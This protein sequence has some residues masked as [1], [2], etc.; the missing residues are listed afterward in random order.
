MKAICTFSL[1]R[2]KVP[3][4]E[5]LGLAA[6]EHNSGVIILV[7]F[8]G[9]RSF[10]TY[11][12]SFINTMQVFLTGK[13]VTLGDLGNMFRWLCFL[14]THNRLPHCSSPST[15]R[16]EESKDSLQAHLLF[17]QE[18]THITKC[19]FLGGDSLF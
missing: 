19:M 17:H 14:S 11:Y 15:C 5:Q 8:V 2:E 1:F 9:M 18:R 16:E 3:L 4:G 13:Q 6:E 10:T 7:T 12:L